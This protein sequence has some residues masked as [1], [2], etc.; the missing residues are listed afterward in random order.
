MGHSVGLKVFEKS[1]F[2][3]LRVMSIVEGTGATE[4]VDIAPAFHVPEE[5]SLGLLEDGWKR[6]TVTS[7]I[8]LASIKDVGKVGGCHIRASGQTLGFTGG[9]NVVGDVSFYYQT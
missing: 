3:L 4:E 6:P 2:G 5:R 9:A 7:N 1:N 8:G